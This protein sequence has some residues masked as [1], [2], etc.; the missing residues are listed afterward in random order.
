[1]ANCLSESDLEDD[2]IYPISSTNAANA[3]ESNTS[4][5]N[6]EWGSF[7]GRTLVQDTGEQAYTTTF[8]FAALGKTGKL[9]I[10]IDLFDSGASRHMSGYRDRFI[11][12]VEIQP[13]PITAADK[14]QFFVNGKGDMYLEVP[15]GNGHS[16]VLLQDVLYSP[17]MGITLVSISRITSAGSSILFCGNTC[18]IYSPSRT[19]IT[20]IPKR[21]GLYRNFTP[22]PQ[23][24]AY[25]G[26][27]KE[28]LSIDQLHRKLGHVGHK[29]IRQLLQKGLVTGVELDESSKPTFCESCKWGKKHCKGS[30]KSQRPKRLATR[31]MLTYGEKPR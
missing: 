22:R 4:A 11:N 2:D 14:R 31:S 25:A 16:R 7:A 26:K 23:H 30:A 29:Y 27:T 19:L 9:A 6:D 18:R 15:N 1:M 20:Q 8:D 3:I 17:T 10:E 24:T 21:G 5:T 13:K 28:S 12:F